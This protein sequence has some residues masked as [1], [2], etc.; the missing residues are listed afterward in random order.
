MAT[1]SSNRKINDT[2]STKAPT[3]IPINLGKPSLRL[4]LEAYYRLVSPQQI[5][6]DNNNWRD[7]FAQIWQK[8]G[9]TVEGERQLA[10]K[11]HKKYGTQ[12][13][14]QLTEGS[15]ST[16]T[17]TN[18]N[19]NEQPQS[20]SDAQQQYTEEWYEL[21]S[22]E[23]DSGVINFTSNCFDPVAALQQPLHVMVEANPPAFALSQQRLERVDQC[24]PYLPTCDPQYRAAVATIRRDAPTMIQRASASCWESTAMPSY[25]ILYQAMRSNQKI[26]ILVRYVDGMRGTITGKLMAY[27][28]HFNLLLQRAH[29]TFSPRSLVQHD[30]TPGVRTV[31]RE[32]ARRLAGKFQRRSLSQVL[33]RGDNVVLV[34]WAAEEQSSHRETVSRYRPHAPKATF[35]SVGFASIMKR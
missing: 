22:Q 10:R 25:A 20:S 23:R 9:G 5:S 12:V 6:D 13:L 28:K 4:R 14:L 27:D 33:V 7:R 16:T 17:T 19:N 32:I 29:E 18:S 26:R 24:R 15:Q 3:S 35:G 11:L 8:Y 31:D 30:D 1:S 2:A 21:R 34:Y